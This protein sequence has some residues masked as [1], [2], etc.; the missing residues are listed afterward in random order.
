MGK[1]W[2]HICNEGIS[3]KLS[4]QSYNK[5]LLSMIKAY[6]DVKLVGIKFCFVLFCF[7]GLHLWHMEVPRPGVKSELQLP[8]YATAT[9]MWDLSH[10]CDLHHSSQ[11]CQILN[12]L[13]EARD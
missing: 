6:F 9:A 3:D 4:V 5:T 13:S 10:A 1:K 11:E 8:A 2:P 7:L 12:P